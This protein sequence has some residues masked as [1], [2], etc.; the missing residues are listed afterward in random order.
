MRLEEKSE[1]MNELNTNSTEDKTCQLCGHDEFDWSFS[2]SDNITI[3]KDGSY[4]RA[5]SG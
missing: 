1:K 2:G 4:E 5:Y 3:N